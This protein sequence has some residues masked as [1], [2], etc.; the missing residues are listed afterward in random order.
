MA[1]IQDDD[2]DVDLTPKQV[3]DRLDRYIVGQVELSQTF[4]SQLVG[5]ANFIDLSCHHLHAAQD[6]ASLSLQLIRRCQAFAQ[7]ALNREYFVA[8]TLTI[9]TNSHLA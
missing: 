7:F 1:S 5:L 3:V 2:L 6:R 4:H 8:N 9:V